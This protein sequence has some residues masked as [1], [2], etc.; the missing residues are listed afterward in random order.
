MMCCLRTLWVLLFTALACSCAHDRTGDADSSR[1][2]TRI[3]FG[4]CADE[5][6]PQPVWD[7]VEGAKPQLLLLLGDNVYGD[8]LDMDVLRAKY[9]KLAA[10]PTFARLRKSCE[11]MA[12]WDDHDYGT[13]DAG[14]EHP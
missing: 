6:G 10:I 8:T 3:A 2:L 12:T 13:N 1:P 14:A 7:A 5:D 11:V 4:C 9:A